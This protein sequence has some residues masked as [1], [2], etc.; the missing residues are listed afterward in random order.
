LFRFVLRKAA[1]TV[2][3]LLVAFGLVLLRLTCRMRYHNDPRLLLR[4]SGVPYVFSVLHAQQLAAAACG[5]RGTAAMVSRSRDGTFVALGLRAVGIKT[6]R[7][8]SRRG[9]EDKGGLSALHE[10]IEH[11]R[12][13]RPAFLA[14]DGPN[15]PRNR[16][17]KGIAV[18]SQQ[19]GATVL[20]VVVVPRRRWIVERSWDRFQIPMPFSTIDLYFGAPMLPQRGEPVE[21]Y[22]R[23]IE[24]ALNELEALRDPVEAAKSPWRRGGRYT[25]PAPTASAA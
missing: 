1:V 8:S 13:G 21:E 9:G 5:D 17:H 3:P 23:R 14:V 18:L 2:G 7:G 10:L 4:A 6:I 19:S 11:V 24:T 25:P 12:T 20:N 22:R 15:G 16:V